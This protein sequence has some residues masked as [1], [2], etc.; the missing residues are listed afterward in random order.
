MDFILLK[1]KEI[2]PAPI[3]IYTTLGLTHPL[4]GGQCVQA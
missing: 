1:I 3:Q 2:H 4:K